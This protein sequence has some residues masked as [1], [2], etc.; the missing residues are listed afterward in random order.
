MPLFLP[1]MYVQDTNEVD[2]RMPVGRW[3]CPVKCSA[4]LACRAQDFP[5]KIIVSVSMS[6]IL[7]VWSSKKETRLSDMLNLCR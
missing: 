7:H 3:V 5:P 4:L 2:E 6:L 1:S